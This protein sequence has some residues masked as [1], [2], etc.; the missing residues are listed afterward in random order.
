VS[1]LSPESWQPDPV[2]R[3]D[4]RLW[5]GTTWTEHVADNNAV[6]T[7]PIVPLPTAPVTIRPSVEAFKNRFR[8]LPLWRW[9]LS[10][11]LIPT[12]LLVLYL[13]AGWLEATA[14]AVF[15]LLC[16]SVLPV[17]YFNVMSIHADERGI[18]ITNQVG[19]RRFVPRQRI[20]AISVGR[21]WTGGVRTADYA[22]IVS[23]EAGQLGRFLLYNWDPEDF[24]RLAAAIGLTLYGRPG[25]RLD[26]AHS[27]RNVERTAR[28][29]AGSAVAGFLIAGA[30]TVGGFVVV[31]I[32]IFARSHH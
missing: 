23:P 15:A 32:L 21:S 4:F 9:I 25:R 18:E 20:A 10:A 6:S 16:A 26:E 1:T 13:D 22:F 17:L 29:L 2:G 31:A 3:H 7:D 14:I 30:L 12:A 27:G 8:T 5:S 24:R 11:L 28:Y 19:F